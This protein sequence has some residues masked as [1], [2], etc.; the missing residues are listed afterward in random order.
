MAVVMRQRETEAP[1][2]YT[3]VTFTF[4]P[5]PEEVN[6]STISEWRIRP[7]GRKFEPRARWRRRITD[8]LRILGRM[9]KTNIEELRSKLLL[10]YP[11]TDP[12][13]GYYW[14][15]EGLENVDSNEL[16]AWSA[17]LEVRSVRVFSKTGE[18]YFSYR[19]T[20]QW[21]GEA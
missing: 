10:P 14:S 8:T 2:N 18:V 21:V 15:I 9:P 17:A 6:R 19:F 20:F 13:E 4:S 1:Y 3:G 11:A 7:R 16:W 5:N 12:R